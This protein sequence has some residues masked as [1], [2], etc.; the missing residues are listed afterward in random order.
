LS[1]KLKFLDPDQAEHSKQ[2]KL[3]VEAVGDNL[4]RLVAVGSDGSV[5]DS[6]PQPESIEGI[7]AILKG[8]GL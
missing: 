6:K 5:V 8:W 1:A 2:V 7:E 4:P 3:M